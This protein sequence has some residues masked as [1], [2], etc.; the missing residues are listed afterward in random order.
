LK[1]VN[2]VLDLKLGATIRVTELRRKKKS[3]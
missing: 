2:Q 1:I 3:V